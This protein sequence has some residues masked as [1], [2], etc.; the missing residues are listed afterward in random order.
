VLSLPATQSVP[1]LVW[2][3]DRIQ[4]APSPAGLQFLLFL[5]VLGRFLHSFTYNHC[6]KGGSQKEDAEYNSGDSDT[7]WRGCDI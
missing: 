1:L 3:V 4:P 2:I 5:C 6:A 7:I